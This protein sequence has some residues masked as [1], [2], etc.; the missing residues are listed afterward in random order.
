MNP[1]ALLGQCGIRVTAEGVE[2]RDNARSVVGQL[3]TVEDAPAGPEPVLAV[4]AVHYGDSIAH[5]TARR[6]QRKTLVLGQG[7]DQGFDFEVVSGHRQDVGDGDAL[8]L[9]QALGGQLVVD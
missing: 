2:A 1:Q 3:S 6:L 5:R 9:T 8:G 7:V 4:A